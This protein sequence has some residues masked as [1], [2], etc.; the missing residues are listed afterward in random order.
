[1]PNIQSKKITTPNRSMKIKRVCVHG[2]SMNINSYLNN[3]TY[4]GEGRH[5]MH[6]EIP[7]MNKKSFAYFPIILMAFLGLSVN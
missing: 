5:L 7:E 3:K 4:S 1:M 2:Y 6:Y